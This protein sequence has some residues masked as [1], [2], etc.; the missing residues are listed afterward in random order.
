MSPK[1]VRFIRGRS[2]PSLT[3]CANVKRAIGPR[4]GPSQ[5]A[6][7]AARLTTKVRGDVSNEQELAKPSPPRLR[8]ARWAVIGPALYTAAFLLFGLTTGNLLCAMIL[9]PPVPEPE[10]KMDEYFMAKARRDLSNLPLVKELR[11]RREEW[12]EYDAY[13]TLDPDEAAHS[14]TATGF[15]G[16]RAIA[17]QRVFWNQSERR[18]IG[19]VFLGS[20]LAGWPMVVHGGASATLLLENLERVAEGP[21]LRSVGTGRATIQNLNISYRKPVHANQLYVIRAEVDKSDDSRPHSESPVQVKA[22]LEATSDGSVVTEAHGTCSRLRGP[23]ETRLSM[24]RPPFGPFQ[25]DALAAR[26]DELL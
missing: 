21:R 16:S 14:M 2:L 25:M 13:M 7:S 12:L 5:Y 1:L 23:C 18:L 3:F 8:R 4:L 19:V 20:S 22:V 26:L 15:Q 11:A 9:P 6:V 10:S 17:V 24:N